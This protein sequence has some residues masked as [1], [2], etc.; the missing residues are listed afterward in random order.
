L[1]TWL[2]CTRVIWTDSN[3]IF[4]TFFKEK[5]TRRCGIGNRI[6]YSV[7]SSFFDYVFFYV[8]FSEKNPARYFSQGYSRFRPADEVDE[9]SKDERRR[10]IGRDP[11]REPPA[12]LE[13]EVL[14]ERMVIS[15]RASRF[16]SLLAI[17]TQN[18]GVNDSQY[19]Y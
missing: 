17:T 1:S 7:P 10:W 16:A 8:N 12:V 4:R 19:I 3:F 18:L 11:R 14:C 15:T 13:Y 5:K 2:V 9:D 6:H